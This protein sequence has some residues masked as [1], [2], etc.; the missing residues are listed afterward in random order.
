M[1]SFF[2]SAFFFL[3]LDFLGVQSVFLACL[4]PTSAGIKYVCC[5]VWFLLERLSILGRLGRPD[6]TQESD[7]V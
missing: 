6:R 5:R 1:R 7:I 4:S 3:R 2:I